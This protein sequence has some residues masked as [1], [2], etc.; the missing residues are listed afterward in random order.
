MGTIFLED[1]AR[2]RRRF[3]QMIAG[4]GETVKLDVPVDPTSGSNAGNV[5]R[6]L[7]E[8]ER[9]QWRTVRSQT[10]AGLQDYRAQPRD[11]WTLCWPQ[12]VVLACSSVF[13]T[14]QVSEAITRGG[15]KALQEYVDQV[16]DPQLQQ[17]VQLVRGDLNS[18]QR[19][20]LGAL[21]VIDVHARDTVTMMVENKVDSVSDFNWVAQLRYSWEPAWKSGQAV[22]KDED[23]LVA[24]IV[25][26]RTL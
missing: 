19:S 23:T 9:M 20:T 11:A 24:K 26:A 8:L 1:D 10:A 6:W 15:H 7:L 5:E 12:Q 4:K 14:S 16:L 18:V 2:S 13:W 22:K 17:I 3:V 21:V 25:N